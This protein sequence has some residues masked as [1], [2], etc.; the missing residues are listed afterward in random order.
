MILDISNG[1]KSGSSSSSAA[2][3]SRSKGTS[4]SSS[5]SSSSRMNSNI[6]ESSPAVTVPK[7]YLDA[8]RKS[9]SSS[10]SSSSSN[11]N[12][13]YDNI[14]RQNTIFNRRDEIDEATRLLLQKYTIEENEAAE[15]NRMEEETMTEI[16][17][18]AERD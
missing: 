12:K 2:Y 6:Q 14:D 15:R 16:F 7:S 3:G 18:Q 11:G 8:H 17:L 4:S 9:L 5:S 1:G 13:R 10:S